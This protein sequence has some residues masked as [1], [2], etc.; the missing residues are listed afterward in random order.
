MFD[1][2]QRGFAEDAVHLLIGAE[3]H[4]IRHSESARGDLQAELG[5]GDDV[6]FCC[7]GTKVKDNSPCRLAWSNSPQL[8]SWR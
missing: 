5:E 8:R 1:T 6:P 2:E 4:D 3:N 7:M